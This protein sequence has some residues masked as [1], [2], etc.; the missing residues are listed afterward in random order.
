MEYSNTP[1][2]LKRYVY[3]VS[4]ASIFPS[5]FGLMLARSSR[6][7]SVAVKGFI[8]NSTYELPMEEP[9]LLIPHSAG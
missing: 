3:T 6:K 1:Q 8:P 7:F 2:F 9:A 5:P 4:I